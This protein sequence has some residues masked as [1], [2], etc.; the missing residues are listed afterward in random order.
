MAD[1][2][3]KSPAQSVANA[4]Q[5]TAQT[6]QAAKAAVQAGAKIA[7]GNVVGGVVDILKNEKLRNAIIAVLLVLSLITCSCLMIVGTAITAA[8]E[9]MSEA[10]EQSWDE[11]WE[12]HGIKSGGNALYQYS[13]GALASASVAAWDSLVALFTPIGN[14]TANGELGGEG[15]AKNDYE[16]TV[17]SILTDENG[18]L[19]GPDGALMKRINLIKDRV[20]QRG[21]QIVEYAEFQYDFQTLGIGIGE[22]L[23]EVFSNPILFGGVDFDKCKVEIDTSPFELTDLQAIKIL[24][25]FSIQYDADMSSVEMWDIMDYCGWYVPGIISSMDT[26]AQA[27]AELGRDIS[28]MITPY[29]MVKMDGK[30]IGCTGLIVNKK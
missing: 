13:V 6:A 12:E 11:N 3:Q 19:T 7:T 30:V 25:M 18:E 10:W 9:R 23:C 4:A 20:K 21:E 8:I 5:K 26:Y 27:A 16:N 2:Q 22:A 14:E 1:E 15:V 29:G 17:D 24:A 28:N